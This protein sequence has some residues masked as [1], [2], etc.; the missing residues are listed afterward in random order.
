MDSLLPA[1]T[2]PRGLPMD[3][4]PRC[5]ALAI[6]SLPHLAG[7]PALELLLRSLPEI[8]AWPQLPAASA[9]ENMYAQ[10]AAGLPGLVVT[11]DGAYCDRHAPGFELE[12]ERLY[13]AHLDWTPSGATP[14]ADEIA[15]IEPGH[16]RGLHALLDLPASGLPARAA[17]KG[18]VTGP[19]S[20]C[21]AVT[22]QDRRPLLY[23]D[24]LR[25]A[26]T[27]LL[28]LKA[29]WQEWALAQLGRPLVLFLDEPYMSTFGSACFNYGPELVR[30]LH[31]EITGGLQATIGV[32]CCGN[33][34]WTLV[35]G[36][37][38][39][40]VSFDA[41]NHAASISLYPSEV[42]EHFAAGGMLAWGIVPALPQDFDGETLESLLSRFDAAVGL[43]AR[44]G[45]DRDLILRRALITPS[46]GLRAQSEDGAARALRLCSRL[47]AR[48]RGRGDQEG[49]ND[50]E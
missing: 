11:T 24:T 9:H 14:P 3:W 41:Y 46:C 50:G 13:A 25:Q 6:G 30:E 16:A 8:V 32:H 12:L 39:R 42:D 44:K 40:I 20:F 26:A 23:D 21:L 38:A 49:A 27:L 47:G 10:F 37:P 31:R 29:A 34:D 33:T 48:L 43:L 17:V 5:A 19:I 28:R 2:P 18:Q 35:L 36:G 15:R 7:G 22:D 4:E 45:I 1:L